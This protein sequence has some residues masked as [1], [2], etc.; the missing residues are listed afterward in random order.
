MH[1]SL[2]DHGLWSFTENVDFFSTFISG[3][4]KGNPYQLGRIVFTTDRSRRWWMLLKTHPSSAT[5]GVVVTLVSGPEKRLTNGLFL[6][7]NIRT[8]KW[9]R[10]CSLIFP[11]YLSVE[12]QMLRILQQ[13]RVKKR[14]FTAKLYQS[15]NSIRYKFQCTFNFR[16]CWAPWGLRLDCF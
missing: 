8:E 15:S 3:C 16:Y 7:G 12:N 2:L 4:L 1:L 14:S 10:V 13:I 11:H 5:A 9:T 6:R